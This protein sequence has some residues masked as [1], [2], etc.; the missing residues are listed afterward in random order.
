LST[1]LK[2]PELNINP[3]AKEKGLFSLELFNF[4]AS[5]NNNSLTTFHFDRV[6]PEDSQQIEVNFY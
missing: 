3:K 2:Y 1:C 5:S 4:N 6:F